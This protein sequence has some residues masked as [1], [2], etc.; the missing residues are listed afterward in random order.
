MSYPETYFYLSCF[1]V[2]VSSVL[3]Y[4]EE[5]NCSQILFTINIMI[6]V[7]TQILIQQWSLTIMFSCKTVM[8]S[9]LP[10]L[11]LS[12]PNRKKNY[13]CKHQPLVWESLC[14]YT[15]HPIRLLLTQMP[16]INVAFHSFIL[17]FFQQF[18]LH[19]EKQLFLLRKIQLYH[20]TCVI[21]V[22]CVHLYI[23]HKA[24]LVSW[25]NNDAEGTRIFVILYMPIC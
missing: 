22:F 18:S 8:T 10:W 4:N 14:S 12:K 7:N 25:T 20:G 5:H 13:G 17:Y 3:F 23:F 1:I 2:L 15:H 6:R 19:L 16:L 9:V 24:G 11:L 21:C